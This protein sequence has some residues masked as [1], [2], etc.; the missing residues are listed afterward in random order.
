MVHDFSRSL[1][2]HVSDC[3]ASSPLAEQ[4][5]KWN[6]LLHHQSGCIFSKYF[7]FTL[8]RHGKPWCLQHLEYY[9]VW[10]CCTSRQCQFSILPDT[11]HKMKVLK[12]SVND[13]KN[14]NRTRKMVEQVEVIS[15]SENRDV[16]SATFTLHLRF[17]YES[18]VLQLWWSKQ[19]SLLDA[20]LLLFQFLK[21]CME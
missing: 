5:G 2:H 13:C 3:F 4:T 1:R 14:W 10:N 17:D 8:R 21:F 19:E 9:G 15:V 6:I 12:N 7:Y 20:P 16:C 18:N 11:A